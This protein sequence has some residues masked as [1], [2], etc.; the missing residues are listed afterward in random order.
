ML[1]ERALDETPGRS[2]SGASEVPIAVTRPWE[3]C[4][5]KLTIHNASMD[6]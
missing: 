4:K 5:V 2:I 3:C 1:C 6:R